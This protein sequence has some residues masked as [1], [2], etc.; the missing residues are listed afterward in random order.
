LIVIQF[1]IRNHAI[2]LNVGFKICEEKDIFCFTTLPEV[3][4]LQIYVV[5]G[6]EGVHLHME[7]LSRE[8][9]GKGLDKP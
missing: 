7:R 8:T 4:V 2:Y 9:S 5:F 1:L 6:T 3:S